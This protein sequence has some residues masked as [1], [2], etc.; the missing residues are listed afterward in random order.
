VK[1]RHLI[2]LVLLAALLAASQT[3]ALPKPRERWIEVRTEHFTLLGNSPQHRTVQIGENLERLRQ[4]LSRSTRGLEV[5]S[6]VETRIYV[7]RDDASFQPYKTRVEGKPANVSGFFVKTNDGNYVAIDASAGHEPYGV[8]YHEYLHYFL[9]NN[10]PDLPLWLNEGLSEFYSTFEWHGR[11]AEL[12]RHVESH[13]YWLAHNEL[14]PLRDLFAISAASPDYNEG[15]RQ[16]TF[17]AQSW[18]LTHYLLTRDAT[19][20]ARLMQ[21]L[22]AGTMPEVALRT[23]YEVE[24]PVLEQALAAYVQG[25]VF[26]YF[27]LTFDEKLS[28][29]RADVRKLERGELLVALGD[30]LMHTPPIRLDEAER[31]FRAALDVRP[32][33]AP[34]YAGLGRVFEERGRWDAAI[35]QYKKAIALDADDARAYAAYGWNLLTA[36]SRG[37]QDARSG[38]SHQLLAARMLFRKSIELDPHNVDNYAGLGKTYLFE[39]G[40]AAEGLAA[41]EHA[42]KLMPSR[43]DILYDLFIVQL[44]AGEEAGARRTLNEGLRPRAESAL[45]HEAE[46]R[47]LEIQ[48]DRA[49]ALF[50]EGND[51]EA[52]TLLEWV[53]REAHDPNLRQFVLSQLM[54]LR[55]FT[56][57]EAVAEIYD[58]AI[59]AA[60]G[61]DLNESARLLREVIMQAEDPTLRLAA[62]SNLRMIEEAVLHN[63]TVE[64]YNRAV[65][66]A[67]AGNL[68]AAIEVLEQAL[69]TDPEGPLRRQVEQTLRELQ[70]AERQRRR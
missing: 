5:N 35:E 65:R 46:D 8:I 33:H 10:L 49:A 70:I 29:V 25:K 9:G 61:G 47:L 21:E 64:R 27:K 2:P 26:N 14:L 62:D 36:F 19:R 45:I 58:R 41:L 4:V 15:Q 42:T 6:P 17:Y 44:N 48:L 16:G 11:T 68:A 50:A 39:N 69:E 56:A 1:R 12:G 57:D 38:T 59:Q 20:F 53:A 31:H 3:R 34:A 18:A 30:L 43:T 13:L 54:S 67:N 63:R 7:F 22:N 55:G 60:N 52:R 28:D 23:I 51:E 37:D 24:I 40:E 32:D 66:E